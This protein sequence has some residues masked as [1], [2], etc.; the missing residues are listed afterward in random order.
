MSTT[1]SSGAASKQIWWCNFCNY[2]TEDQAD[3]LKHS[4]AEVLKKQGK[5][6][7][8]GDKTHCG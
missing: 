6:A 5:P 2:K 3:Y 7:G 8:P 1:P 4:C